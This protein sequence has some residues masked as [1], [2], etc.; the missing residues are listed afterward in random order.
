MNK[1]LNLP[2]DIIQNQPIIVDLLKHPE[3]KND[4]AIRYK[5]LKQK[6]KVVVTS[7]YFDPLHYGHIELIQLAKRLGDYLIVVLNND[8]Q[9]IQKKGFTFMPHEEKSKI[10]SELRSVDE[11]FIS[12]D[13]DQTQ[14]KTLE[15]IQPNIFAKGGDRYSYE[16]PE[17]KICERFNIEII[18]GLGKKIQSSSTLIANANKIQE[19]LKRKPSKQGN[20]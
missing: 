3:S 15:L 11:V 5:E 1:K 12:I 19:L 14:C 7:G 8:D 16:I 17:S 18:D 6:K 13:V 9:T 10:L 4:I 2:S 20:F